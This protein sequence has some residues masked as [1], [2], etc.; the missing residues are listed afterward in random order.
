MGATRIDVPAMLK[1]AGVRKLGTGTLA[2]AIGM[3]NNDMSELI[4]RGVGTPEQVQKLAALLGESVVPGKPA[5]ATPEPV[6]TK[7]DESLVT[8][9]AADLIEAVE[10]GTVSKEAALAAE[11]SREHPRSTVLAFLESA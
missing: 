3:S 6:E 7:I 9:R 5:V 4:A 8:M 1:L 10:N 11:N 2:Q